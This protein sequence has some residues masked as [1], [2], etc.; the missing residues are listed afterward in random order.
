MN[1]R[2]FLL[3]S[4]SSLALPT[5][6]QDTWGEKAGYPTGWGPAGS[7]QMWESYKEYHVGNFSGGLEKMFA[8][9]VLKASPKPSNLVEAKRKVKASLLMDASDYANTYN[10]TGLLIARGDEIWH[11]QYRFNRT[12]EMRFFGWSMTK[13]IVG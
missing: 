7:L 2:H 9:Q 4:L 11:E 8:H 5:W 13:S 3:G 10:L 6:A 12:A 1:K